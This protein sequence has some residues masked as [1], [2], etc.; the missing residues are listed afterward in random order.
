MPA[1][2]DLT[3]QSFGKLTV[4]ESIGAAPLKEGHFWL[5]RCECGNARKV[6]TK[7]LRAKNCPT[8]RC[9]ECVRFKRR[10]EQ[11][12]HGS[13][14]GWTYGG[15]ERR[16]PALLRRPANNETIKLEHVWR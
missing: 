15:G 11:I 10:T 2:L 12:Y 14:K 16:N 13:P 1:R 7:K 9:E 6:T 4:V 3:G 8:D 5:C